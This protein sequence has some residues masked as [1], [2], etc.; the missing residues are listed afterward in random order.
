MHCHWVVVVYAYAIHH[1]QPML[2]HTCALIIPALRTP[3]MLY[4]LHVPHGTP[5]KPVVTVVQQLVLKINQAT[6]VPSICE[7]KKKGRGNWQL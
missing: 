5:S 4:T 3:P 2:Q 1:L 6:H 7:V